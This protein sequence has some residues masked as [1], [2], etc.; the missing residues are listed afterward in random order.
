[1]DVVIAVNGGWYSPSPTHLMELSVVCWQQPAPVYLYRIVLYLVYLL[2]S[3]HQVPF[4]SQ[5]RMRQSPIA[6]TLTR[7]N[8][9]LYI[10]GVLEGVFGILLGVF[11]I[12]DCVCSIR[13]GVFA[14]Q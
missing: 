6:I 9:T 2:A 1:M 5:I 7:V 14:G 4:Q 8:H 3:H 12:W 13:N 10:F 11:G